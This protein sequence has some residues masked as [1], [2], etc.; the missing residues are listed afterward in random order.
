MLFG[1]QSIKS[2]RELE[3][4]R[5]AGDI[6]THALSAACESLLTGHSSA[7]A[8][9]LAAGILM[10]AGGGFHR[11]D[12]HHG[13]DTEHRVISMNLYGYDTTSPAAGDVVRAWIMGPIFQGYWM[14]PGRSLICGNRPTKAQR[15]LLEGAV[16]V[17]DAVAAAM[18]PGI[19]PR[20]LGVLGGAIARK[21]GYFD[22]PQLKVPL[23][24]H[25]LGTN[26]IPYV[27]P[28]GEGEAD[29]DGALHYD[30]PLEA[31]MVMAAEI[32]LTHPGV[33]T[34]GFEQN[35]IVTTGAPGTPHPHTDA[36]RVTR[37]PPRGPRFDSLP[38]LAY[39]NAL[40]IIG[41]LGTLIT[42]AMLEGWAHL[43][44]S[45]TRLG[46]VAA[47]EL[48]G[49]ALGSLS[50]LYWQRRWRWRPVALPSILVA[51]AGNLACMMVK[52]F[53]GVCV[54]RALV[55]ISGGLLIGPLF[56][57]IGQ[58][59]IAGTH[60]RR[61][62]LHSDRRRGGLHV[63]QRFRA[64]AVGQSGPVPLDGSAFRCA[65][66]LLDSIAA[67]VAHGAGRG[68][69]RA[70]RTPRIMARLSVTPVL[71]PFHRGAGGGVHLSRGIRPRR[72]K[73][74]GR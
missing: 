57:G 16:E 36:L 17:V 39:V 52:D 24:G 70:Q 23:L 25:G 42:P 41:T 26:F 65:A 10:R 74:L 49:L 28:I 53:F 48:A 54:L 7:E 44:W 21:H 14:D 12:I 38:R 13:A 33:G 6:V 2:A 29:P 22:H 73:P 60:H 56:S 66:S 11:I 35:L 3:A 64:R 27:I 45:A 46:A 18:R 4:Y 50:G 8:A 32:F 9:A 55:G 63:F 30:V 19:T 68:P 34:A 31:G 72:G 69:T 51:I 1:P 43:N 71:R 61:D 59:E 47:V 67:E 58:F 20:Q 62:H 37:L 15:A 5:T 40:F